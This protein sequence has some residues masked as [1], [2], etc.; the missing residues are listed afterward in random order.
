MLGSRTRAGDT[1]LG[2]TSW[3][4]SHGTFGLSEETDT[5]MTLATEFCHSYRSTGVL[6]QIEEE[7]CLSFNE[8]DPGEERADTWYVPRTKWVFL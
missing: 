1:W 5:L 2:E 3:T 6:N 4:L 8:Y 7:R